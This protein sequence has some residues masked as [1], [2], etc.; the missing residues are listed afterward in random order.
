MSKLDDSID[1]RQADHLADI[2]LGIRHDPLSKP[3]FTPFEVKAPDLRFSRAVTSERQAS[4][5]LA[6]RNY[7]GDK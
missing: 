3:I 6:Q 1:H 2:L 4:R 7:W 5:K